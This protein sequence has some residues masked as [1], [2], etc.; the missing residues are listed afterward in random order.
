MSS[1]PDAIVPLLSPFASRFDARTW[2]KAQRLLVGAVLAP[3]RRTVC[4]CLRALGRQVE[5][6]F[7]STTRCS[8][9]TRWSALAASRR[10]LALLL[11]LLDPSGPWCL[12][13]TRPSSST[14]G[15]AWKPRGV[16]G[17]G[18]LL[19]PP[20]RQGHGAALAQL[21]WLTDIPWARP[22]LTVLV[23]SSRYHTE[24][25]RRHKTP[26]D[27]ARQMLCVL[28]RWLPD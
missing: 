21:M 22:A 15:R 19:A 12:A 20:F 17:R 9:R 14:R 28:R 25:G 2:R 27:R 18:A 23:P 4:A 7:A 11:R 5:P 3:G 1:L 8:K 26:I 6:D 13:W 10:L 16:P 24:L